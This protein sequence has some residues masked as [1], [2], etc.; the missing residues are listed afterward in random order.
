MSSI[1]QMDNPACIIPVSAAFD[2]C[3]GAVLHGLS[4]DSFFRASFVEPER[5]SRISFAQIGLLYA[6]MMVEMDDLF[7]GLGRCAIP[8]SRLSL[9]FRVMIG[10]ATLDSALN[11]LIQFHHSGQPVFVR[12]ETSAS[13]AKLS[14]QCDDSIGGA[15]GALIEDL[16]I[17]HIFGGLSYF[18]GR[19]F[20]ATAAST[21]NQSNPMIGVPHYSMLVPLQLASSAAIHFPTPL[22]SEHRQGEPTDEIYW[23]VCENWLAIATGTIIRARDRSTSIRSLNT[24]ALC[25]ELGISPATFRRRNSL[26]GGN[27]R[28]FREETLIEASLTLLA[29][30][31]RSISSIAAE[32]GYADVRSYRRFIKGATGHTPDQL[33]M[34]SDG[35][36]MRAFEPKVVA[37]IKDVT[38]RLS[39]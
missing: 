10:C 28:R 16:Y 33:R 8:T 20:P 5:Q 25:M 22:L 30:D 35:A 12:L 21:R 18:V 24:K 39:R 14:I 32:L 2:R 11:S 3:N 38:T 13:E 7:I 36:V 23:S 19:P 37:K 26:E 15:N 34:S 4:R 1:P 27:F 6:N 9:L 17:Q 29:D 31:S